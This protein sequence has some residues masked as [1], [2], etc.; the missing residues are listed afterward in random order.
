MKIS[1]GGVLGG[2]VQIGRAPFTASNTTHANFKLAVDGK[3]VAKSVYVTQLNWADFVFAPTYRLMPLPELEQYLQTYRHLPAIP[4]AQEV[5]TDG[6]NVGVMQ[7]NLLQ[8]VE[9]LTLHVIELS[10]QNQQLQVELRAL[11]AKVTQAASSASTR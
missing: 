5:A 8:T 6:V 7:A 10:K 2:Q 3:I 4:S 11:A 9:E 1:P